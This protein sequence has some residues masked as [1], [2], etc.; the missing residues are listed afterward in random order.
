MAATYS[1]LPVEAVEATWNATL[2]GYRRESIEAA[3]ASVS[4]SGGPW[5]PSLPEFVAV[6]RHM[7]RPEH[8]VTKR[9]DSPRSSIDLAQ[10]TI[11]AAKAQMQDAEDAVLSTTEEGLLGRLQARYA[12][13]AERRPALNRSWAWR[14]LI[15]YAR[16]EPLHPTQ[17]AMAKTAVRL[18]DEQM[19]ALRRERSKA[20]AEALQ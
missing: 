8:D 13:E 12:A 18:T 2:V 16:G 6:I 5:P 10:A 9:L 17:L 1:G 19:A 20:Q 3:I 14:L 11:E 15:N 4:T 7:S